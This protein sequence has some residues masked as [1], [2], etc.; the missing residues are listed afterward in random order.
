MYSSV[1]QVSLTGSLTTWKMAH[2]YKRIVLLKGLEHISDH[3]FESFKSVMANDLRLEETMRKEYNKVQIA[4]MMEYEFPTDAG[5]GKLI[6]FCEDVHILK[7]LAETLKEEKSK[8][9]GKTPLTTSNTAASVKG[10]TP[11]T[12]SNTAASDGGETSTAQVSLRNSSGLAV[13]RAVSSASSKRKS[14]NKEKTRVRKTKQSEGPDHPPCPEKATASCQSP[15]LQTS[16][17]ASS[18][19]SLTKNQT[20]QTPNQSISRGAILQKDDM[21][22]MVLNAIDPFVYESSEDKVKKMFHATVATVNEY[23]RVKVFNIN[24]K[25]KFKK[26]NVI[27]ISNYFKFKGILEINEASSVFEAGPDQKI[28]VSNSLIRKANKSPQI[29]DFHNYGPGALVYGLFTLHKK[30]VN[31]KNT[32]YEIKQGKD[33]IEVVGNGKWYNINCET[34]DKLRLFCFQLKTIN[35]QLKLVCGDHSFIKVTKVGKK[36]NTHC[37]LEAKS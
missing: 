32:I 16:S 20:T 10:K 14:I 9:K 35:K 34:G 17:L 13:H 7:R 33:H 26:K 25:E 4:D 37:A 31:S 19:T 27:I 30:K 11:P 2:E 3:Y 36:K 8:V 5:L 29:S 23:F 18:N 22:V 28:E 6:E 21:T 24:L 12:T 1:C 15:E